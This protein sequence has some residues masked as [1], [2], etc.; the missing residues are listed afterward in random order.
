[1]SNCKFFHNLI[2]YIYN[3]P[4]LFL[5]FIPSYFIDN[6]FFNN[7]FFKKLSQFNIIL[8]K[9]LQ[10]TYN[11]EELWSKN[12]IKIIS[13][14]CDNV[15][16]EEYEIDYNTLY[17]LER[18][19]VTVSYKPYRSGSVFLIYKGVYNNDDIII[20][21]KRNNIDKKIKRDLNFMNFV[22]N[23]I[24]NIKFNFMESIVDNY[25]IYKLIITKQTNYLIE[26]ENQINFHYILKE[27]K[28]Y[29]FLSYM[30][31]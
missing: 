27:I 9:V 21:I 24:K 23:I 30:K 1:M 18:K 31:I 22:I 13:Q 3:I 8:L 6:D 25:N 28:I 20:K 10:S 11:T 14:Y 12:K 17:Y 16:Y 4:I 26:V 15:P 2:Y 5:Y 19:G 7:I 29:I